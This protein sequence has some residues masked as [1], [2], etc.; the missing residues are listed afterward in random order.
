MPAFS[1]AYLIAIAPNCGALNPESE[2]RKA[3]IGV[4]CAEMI[5]ECAM[6]FCEYGEY[7]FAMDILRLSLMTTT[8][9]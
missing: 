7:Y 6:L 9:I 4:L 5:Y 8:L 1:K 2:P 3:P